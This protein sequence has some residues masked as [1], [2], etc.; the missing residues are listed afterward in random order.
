MKVI[1]RCAKSFK[2]RS[3]KLLFH[4]TLSCHYCHIIVIPQIALLLE[5]YGNCDSAIPY[6]A[7]V[8]VFTLIAI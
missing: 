3:V 4:F 2:C 5:Q 7:S 6:M 8:G 1:V